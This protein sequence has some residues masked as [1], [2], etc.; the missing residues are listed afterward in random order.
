MLTKYSYVPKVT[1]DLGMEETKKRKT[2]WRRP[3]EQNRLLYLSLPSGLRREAFDSNGHFMLWN[4]VHQAWRVTDFITFTNLI[5][6][7]IPLV[8][9]KIKQFFRCFMTNRATWMWMSTVPVFKFYFLW[10]VI[11]IASTGR[12]TEASTNIAVVKLSPEKNI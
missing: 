7:T 11:C 5:P 4:P 12:P 6:K 1:N 10:N 9:F 3:S 2:F 8:I